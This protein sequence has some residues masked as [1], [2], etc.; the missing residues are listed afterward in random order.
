MLCLAY[1]NELNSDEADCWIDL[2]PG[3]CS[4]KSEWRGSGK[5]VKP[6][7]CPKRGLEGECDEADN[8]LA[9]TQ[10]ATIR[11]KVSAGTQQQSRAG[12]HH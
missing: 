6:D 3:V 7:D 11:S 5:R 1:P 2:E 12:N 10:T 4:L 8:T 9:T